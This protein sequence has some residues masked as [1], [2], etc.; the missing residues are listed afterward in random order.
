MSEHLAT[1]TAIYEAFGRGDVPFILERLDEN[2]TWDQGL[3]ATTV[4]YL[5]PGTGREHVVAFFTALAA[6][7]RFDVFEPKVMLAGE[8][9]VMV[10]VREAGVNLQTGRE[11]PEDLAAH[12]WTFGPDGRVVAFRHIG[13]LATHE[14]AAA[15]LAGATATPA[16]ASV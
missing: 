13:D 4:P 2:I 15:P 5:Q 10:A 14:A 1:V 11:I 9:H 7:V 12:L 3:R 6:N 16:T 8:D